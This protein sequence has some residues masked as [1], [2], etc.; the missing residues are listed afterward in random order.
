MDEKKIK[1]DLF[2]CLSTDSELSALDMDE[3][4]NDSWPLDRA[5]ALD[6]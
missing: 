3:G 6:Q 1:S 4:Y 5:Y 2:N